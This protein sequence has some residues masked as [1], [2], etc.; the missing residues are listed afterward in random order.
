MEKEDAKLFSENMNE[1]QCKQSNQAATKDYEVW[2]TNMRITE[3]D[4]TDIYHRGYEKAE[5]FAFEWL[6]ANLDYILRFG[7]DG[8][9]EKI[10]KE[11]IHEMRK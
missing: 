6:S 2:G 7:T 10:L 8:S 4:Y 1:Y 5:C 11:F 3:D 9:R